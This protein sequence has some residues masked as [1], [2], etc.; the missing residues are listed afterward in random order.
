MWSLIWAPG[1]CPGGIEPVTVGLNVHGNEVTCH[2]ATV[3]LIYLFLIVFGQ[4]WSSMQG[5]HIHQGLLVIQIN[6]LLSLLWIKPEM[7][8]E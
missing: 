1:K 3:W 6:S 5:R 7:L 2:S 8:N 4:L